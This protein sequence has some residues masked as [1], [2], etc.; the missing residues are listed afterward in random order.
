MG[1]EE[2]LIQSYPHKGYNTLVVLDAVNR[3]AVEEAE[4]ANTH[5]GYREMVR[6]ARHWGQRRWAVK[7]CRGAGRYLALR[8]VAKGEVVSDV[9][10]KLAVR[11]FSQGHGRKTDRDDAVP[12]GVAAGT[13]LQLVARGLSNAEIAGRLVISP[14]TAKSHVRNILRKLDS[15]DR[16]ALVALALRNRPDHT[17][18]APKHE[19]IETPGCLRLPSSLQSSAGTGSKRYYTKIFRRLGTHPQLS[20]PRAPAVRQARL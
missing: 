4:F 13:Y 9:P 3:R 15:H 10:A 16:A 1:H 8:L 11:V 14:L 7:G 5:A 19:T 2:V 6:F 17:R 20:V 18:R 12:I